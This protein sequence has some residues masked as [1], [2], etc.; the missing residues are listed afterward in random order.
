MHAEGDAQRYYDHALGVRCAIRFLRRNPKL[1]LEGHDGGLGAACGA[2][3]CATDPSADLIRCDSLQG[4][5]PA[6]RLRVRIESNVKLLAL[7]RI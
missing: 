6:T 3:L 7:T 2:K 4:L 1:V 5:E